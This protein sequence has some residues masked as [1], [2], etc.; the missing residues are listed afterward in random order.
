MRFLFLISPTKLGKI[1]SF[2]KTGKSLIFYHVKSI[3]RYFAT[4][5]YMKFQKLYAILEFGTLKLRKK[6]TL[7]KI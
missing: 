3:V 6:I 1:V 4:R 7:N 2:N 5:N